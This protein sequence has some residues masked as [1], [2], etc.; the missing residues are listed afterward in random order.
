M[1]LFCCRITSGE[2][3]MMYIFGQCILCFVFFSFQNKNVLFENSNF[4]RWIENAECIA[5]AHERRYLT[6]NLARTWMNKGRERERDKHV[7][8]TNATLFRPCIHIFYMRICTLNK[9]KKKWGKKYKN[10][11]SSCLNAR[12][13]Y[14]YMY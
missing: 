13:K 9:N 4:I 1:L 7:N 6:F 2:W 5:Y 8:I 12:Y 11:A 3:R 10:A 14:R